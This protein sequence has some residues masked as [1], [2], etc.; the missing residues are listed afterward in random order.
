MDVE[1]AI[2]DDAMDI[3]VFGSEAKL[4]KDGADLLF[5]AIVSELGKIN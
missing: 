2:R 4:G 5:S 3:G 1:V